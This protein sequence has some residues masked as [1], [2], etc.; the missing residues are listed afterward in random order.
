M[1]Q[2]PNDT[3]RAWRFPAFRVLALLV[4]ICC[5]WITVSSWAQSASDIERFYLGSYARLSVL[6][7]LSRAHFLIGR[8]IGEGSAFQVLFVSTLR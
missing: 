8:S 1:P 4:A 6:P 2:N 7:N 3:A 5:S